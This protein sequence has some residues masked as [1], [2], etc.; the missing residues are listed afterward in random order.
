VSNGVGG[1]ISTSVMVDKQA[2]AAAF[3]WCWR[4]YQKTPRFAALVANPQVSNI[5]DLQHRSP[6]IEMYR[7]TLEFGTR[8]PTSGLQA[9]ETQR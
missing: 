8:I 3:A 2:R 9:L 6:M 5:N 1:S 7:I 4:V